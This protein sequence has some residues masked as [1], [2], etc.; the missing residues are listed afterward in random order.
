MTPAVV[1]SEMGKRNN[2]SS[3]TP[4]KNKNKEGG[5]VSH[6][7]GEVSPKLRGHIH[8]WA[9]FV[10]CGVGAMVLVQAKD[11]TARLA[12][13]IYWLSLLL[14]YGCSALYHTTQWP[15]AKLEQWVG[16]ADHASIFFLIAG[17]YTPLCLCWF[18][19]GK[20]ANWAG[21]VLLSVW[22]IAFVGVAKVMLWPD[23]PRFLNVG[24]YIA[25][26]LT[27]LP[28]YSQVLEHVGL[29]NMLFFIGCGAF[30]IVGAMF[31]AL[32][33]PDL[34]PGHFGYHVRL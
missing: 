10:F 33:K 4:L 17:S 20:A 13:A 34:F 24:L 26:G 25:C 19:W 30:Y 8:R 23:A 18:P 29:N 3:S 15:N 7:S 28:F 1:T 5:I 16:Q 14:V 11:L 21:Q 27:M 12:F 6:L 9:F 32:R 2:S 22:I 31:Y